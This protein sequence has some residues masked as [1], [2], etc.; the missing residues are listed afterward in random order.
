MKFL[1]K[2]M[3]YVLQVQ[4]VEISIFE[5]NRIYSGDKIVVIGQIC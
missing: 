1:F 2:I 5:G 4:R 3:I